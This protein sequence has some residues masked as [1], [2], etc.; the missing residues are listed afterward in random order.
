MFAAR[1]NSKETR[2]LRWSERERERDEGEGKKRMRWK[3]C[4]QEEGRKG[5]QGGFH[6][7]LHA[8]LQWNVWVQV[9]PERCLP[10]EVYKGLCVCCKRTV[11]IQVLPAP[12]MFSRRCFSIFCAVLPWTA[13]IRALPQ[14]CF[15]ADGYAGLCAVLKFYSNMYGLRSCPKNVSNAMYYV[16]AGICVCVCVFAVKCL[17]QG[18]VDVCEGFRAFVQ[19]NVWIQVLPLRCLQGDV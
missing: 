14:R 13:W 15:Q 16:C 8:F 12:T 3:G 1:W 2:V 10:V 9:L 4:S 6:A 18:P 11:C 19:W 7:G 17:D 5:L